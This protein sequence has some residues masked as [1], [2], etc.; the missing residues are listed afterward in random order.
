MFATVQQQAKCLRQ[1]YSIRFQALICQAG[2]E[3][4]S[5]TV[6]DLWDIMIK[7]LSL[8]LENI[9]NKPL[10]LG[11]GHAI[12]LIVICHTLTVVI[13]VRN[14]FMMCFCILVVQINNRLVDGQ[15][16][17]RSCG[18][19]CGLP[20]LRLEAVNKTLIHPLTSPKTGYDSI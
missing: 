14:L 9:S 15:C 4:F 16:L 1:N 6:K 19:V 5:P 10:V 13:A 8:I 20:G 17:C 18:R 2:H 12:W 7:L 3:R 11:T